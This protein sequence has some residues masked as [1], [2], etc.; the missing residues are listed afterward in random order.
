MKE[1]GEV[2]S[3]KGLERVIGIISYATASCERIRKDP[4][5][6]SRRSEICKEA[7]AK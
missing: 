5:A 6:S 1:I 3:I 2:S 7:E 4:W